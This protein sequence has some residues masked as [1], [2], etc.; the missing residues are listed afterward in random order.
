MASD[1]QIERAL[2]AL[3]ATLN[4]QQLDH[5]DRDRAQ[6]VVSREG[7]S[8]DEGGGV[9]DETGAR[10]GALRQTS[11]GEWIAERQNETAE[12]SD[13]AIPAGSPPSG[14]KRLMG[15]LKR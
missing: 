3:T 5:L 14:V 7:L 2:A 4:D 13:T 12:H 9:H 15:K 10:V 6:A 1:V 8:V 11:S